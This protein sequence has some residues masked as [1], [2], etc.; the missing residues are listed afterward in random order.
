M[1]KYITAAAL[2]AALAGA[3]ACG[4]GATEVSAVPASICDTAAA[5]PASVLTPDG[6]VSDLAVSGKLFVMNEAKGLVAA[7]GCGGALE[8]VDELGLGA[9]AAVEGALYWTSAEAAGPTLKK[10]APSGGAVTTVASSAELIADL[11]VV[12]GGKAALVVT[13]KTAQTHQIF[14]ESVDLA[15]GAVTKHLTSAGRAHG[16]ALRDGKIYVTLSDEVAFTSELQAIPIAGGTPVILASGPGTYG[17]LA[18][19]GEAVIFARANAGGPDP[20]DIVGVPLEGGAVT[21]LASDPQSPQ[22]LA[23]DDEDVYWTNTAYEIRRAPLAG[24]TAEPIATHT[25]TP[26][27][28]IVDQAN[29]FWAD[30]SGQVFRMTKP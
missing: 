23:V 8:V 7:P 3:A 1:R 10:R 29:L 24:G 2:A 26:M 22:A 19:T 5:S 20:N 28:L 4:G 18:L 17:H 16:L 6:M 21:T 15:S 12:D 13:D 30:P 25:D 11:L 9:V 27:S 14:I